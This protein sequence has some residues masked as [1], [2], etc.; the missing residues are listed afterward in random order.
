MG[1]HFTGGLASKELWDKLMKEAWDALPQNRHQQTTNNM[2]EQRDA[3]APSQAPSTEELAAMTESMNHRSILKI[4]E[5]CHSANRH[6]CYMNGDDSQVGWKDAP[7]WVKESAIKGIQFLLANPH[8]SPEDQHEAWCRDKYEAGWKY[9][10][11]KNPDQKE[12]PCLVAYGELPLDQQV[13]DSIY[14]GVAKAMIAK[15]VSV[16]QLVVDRPLTDGE[17]VMNIQFN[18]GGN[19]AVNRIKRAFADLHDLCVREADH[20][21]LTIANREAKVKGEAPAISH[22]QSRKA[23]QCG[24]LMALALTSLEVGQMEAVKSVTR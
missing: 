17:D 3:L 5:M 6:W 23:N 20:H 8:A 11:T 12:H 19:P 9:A 22:L 14:Q 21:R 18:P 1:Y 13:K 15:Y 4:A 10:A 24:R 16:G 2:Q 7:D